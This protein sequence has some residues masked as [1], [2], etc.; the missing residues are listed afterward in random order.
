M[1]I[2]IEVYQNSVRMPLKGLSGLRL[3]IRSTS[4]IGLATTS[5]T[6]VSPRVRAGAS[7]DC[8]SSQARRALETGAVSHRGRACLALVVTYCRS[9][10]LATALALIRAQA[11]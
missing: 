8:R 9:G 1:S 5:S 2:E 6:S 10:V 4:R 3:G 7:H 11:K